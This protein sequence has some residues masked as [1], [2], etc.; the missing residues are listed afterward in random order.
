[1]KISSIQTYSQNTNK[2]NTQKS[3][4]FGEGLHYNTNIPDVNVKTLVEGNSADFMN[5]VHSTLKAGWD[6]IDI[7][8][9]IDHFL[10]YK[11][12][13]KMVVLTKLL[14]SFE[15]R[16][17]YIDDSKKIADLAMKYARKENNTVFQTA[18]QY[19]IDEL[20]YIE[21]AISNNKIDNY[22]KTTYVKAFSFIK[23]SKFK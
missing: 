15:K 4:N 12:V 19:K 1:M 8:K 14:E 17:E 23:H 10:G 2:N 3:I 11:D 5:E 20:S 21:D 13:D 7:A 16:K 6:P 22:L 9:Q 18:I